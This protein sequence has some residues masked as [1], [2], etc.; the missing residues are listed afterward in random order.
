MAQLISIG[1][2]TFRTKVGA[3]QFFSDIRD[4]YPDGARIGSEDDALLRELLACHPETNEKTGAGV[5]FFS[6]ATDTVFRRTRHFVVHRVDG[7]SSDFSFHSCID[8]RND[9][10]DRLEALRGAVEDQIV[11]FRDEAF[12]RHGPLTCPLRGVP[13]T[14]EAYHV[15]HEPP[16]VFQVLVARW[17]Q[18]GRLSLADVQITAPADNQIV[19]RMTN[20]EQISSWREHHRMGAK[21]RMLSPRGN[22]SDAKRG[23]AQHD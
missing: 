12:A 23:K 11:A 5:A 16:A 13:V 15:D 20:E 2:V 21:L 9:K 1:S 19:A 10:R 18:I 22:L 6:A 7:S 8:G 3:K 4:R 17:L 14:R